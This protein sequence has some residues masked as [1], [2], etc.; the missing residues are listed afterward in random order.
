M[1]QT[2]RLTALLA[3]AV[4]PLSCT[5]GPDYQQPLTAVPESLPGPSGEHSIADRAWA[6]VF[7]DPVLRSLIA[8]ALENNRDL[9]IAAHRIEEARAITGV[10]A[11]EFFPNLGASGSAERTRRARSI[12]PP[13]TDR[14]VNEFRLGG[15]LSYEVDLWGRVRRSNEA[16]RAAL[17]ASQF[18]RATIETTIIAAV[19]SAYIDLRALDRQLQIASQTVESRRRSLD[20]VKERAAQGVTSELE[21]GQAEVL[22][23]QAEV[24]IPRIQNQ[25]ATTSN[26]LS[27]LL[28]RLPGD[29]PR[30]RSLE[31]LDEGIAVT[32][33]LPSNL[34]LRRPDILGAEQDLVA[35][36]ADIGIAR[37]AYFPSL[38]L[39]GRGGMASTDLDR[40]LRSDNITLA[41]AADL[42][43]PIFTAG[44]ISSSIRATEARRDQ[45]L[46]RYESVILTAFRESADALATHGH[47]NEIVRRQQQLVDSLD[48]VARL[49]TSRY[50]GGAS[51]FLEVLDAERNAFEGQLALTDAR[52]LKLQSVVAA[53]RALG[54][55]WAR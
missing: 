13:G 19:A 32:G 3:A 17:L 4:L 41:G 21:V 52:R 23:H 8:E 12:T 47:A 5:M 16:S 26:A 6:D 33:G 1:T 34:L 38:S 55:G 22:L 48:K 43:A 42:A 29:I 9:A 44:R 15:L 37:T 14:E 7:T 46:A 11:S 40:L 2:L 31:A 39:T 50:E 28:G 24:S 10:A 49:A 54:G 30:G 35:L 45:A 53:Y 20:L 51:S 25:L 36:N 27:T 18:G